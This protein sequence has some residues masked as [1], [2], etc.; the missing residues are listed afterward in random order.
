MDNDTVYVATPGPDPKIFSGTSLS[1]ALTRASQEK[2]RVVVAQD[3]GRWEHYGSNNWHRVPTRR[4][5]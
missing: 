3:G 2:V 1:Q 4:S 5:S